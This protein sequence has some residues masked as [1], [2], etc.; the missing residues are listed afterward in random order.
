MKNWLLALSGC[1]ARAARDRSAQE[2]HRGEFG[3]EVGQVGAALAGPLGIAALGHEAGDH[4][5]EGQPVVK[6]LAD[7]RLDPLDMV[8]RRSGRSWITTVPPFDSSSI[9]WLAGSAATSGGRPMLGSGGASRRRGAAAI[10]ATPRTA[11]RTRL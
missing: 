10:S 6:A 4:A 1:S 9:S 7:Q 3:L 5:V 11:T 2:R 8:G